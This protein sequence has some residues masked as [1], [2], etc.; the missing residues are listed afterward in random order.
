LAGSAVTSPAAKSY[1]LYLH[2]ARRSRLFLRY[3]DEGVTLDAEGIAW[4]IGGVAQKQRYSDIFSVRL[5]SAQIAR[6]PTIYTCTIQF[7][8]GQELAITSATEY[9]NGDDER[10][11]LYG[12]FVRDFHASIP[13]EERDRIRFLAGNSETRQKFLWIVLVIAA[14]FFVGL[15]LGL[16]LYLRELEVLWVLLAGAGLIYPLYRSAEANEPRDYRCEYLPDEVTPERN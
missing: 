11:L 4:A 8:D 15:P 9:G 2:D 1:S 5:Q 16:L 10:A 13:K 7:R 14:L 6:S 3:Q 12:D